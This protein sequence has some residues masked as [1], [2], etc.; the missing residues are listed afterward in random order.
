MA[1]LKIEGSRRA[2][3]W[4]GVENIMF[5]ILNTEKNKFKYELQVQG[6]VYPHLQYAIPSLH[7][8]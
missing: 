4:T 7:L 1:S 2:I 6:G 3:G 5:E 8:T